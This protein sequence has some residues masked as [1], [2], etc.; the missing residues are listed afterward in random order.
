[1]VAVGEGGP[2]VLADQCAYVKM[3]SVSVTPTGVN[4]QL[5]CY[6]ADIKDDEPSQ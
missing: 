5:Y 6:W 3:I 1:M 2:V 4:T